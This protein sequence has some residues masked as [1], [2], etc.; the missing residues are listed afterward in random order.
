MA[1]LSDKDI[2]R[3]SQDKYFK[4]L[5]IAEELKVDYV[6]FHSQINP[7]LNGPEIFELNLCQHAD[8]IN[9][10]MGETSYEGVVLI[11]NIFEK[12]PS[13]ILRLIE[14]IESDKVKINFDLG[15]AKLSDTN[16]EDWIKVL[17][18]HISYIHFHSNNG[19][20]DQHKSPSDGEIETLY[21]LIDKYKMDPVISLEYKKLNLKKEIERFKE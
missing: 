18:S 1:A 8:F 13:D 7:L 6:I 15:H 19:I 21:S 3:V 5:E 4:T 17:K 20:Y 10:L 14:K 11:E 9:Y 16:I 2:R 12:K